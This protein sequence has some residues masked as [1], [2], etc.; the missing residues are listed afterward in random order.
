MVSSLVGAMALPRYE[1]T[2]TI[3]PFRA[4]QR[5]GRCI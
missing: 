2:G 4:A 3:F 5:R 1:Q